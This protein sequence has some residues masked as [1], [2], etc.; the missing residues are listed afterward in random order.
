MLQDARIVESACL[1]L[2]RIAAALANNPEQ[3]QTWPGLCLHTFLM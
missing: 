3:V 2:S 1:A